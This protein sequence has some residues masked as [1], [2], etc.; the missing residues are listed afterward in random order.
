[1]QQGMAGY[2]W[3]SFFIFSDHQEMIREGFHDDHRNLFFTLFH[4]VN[5]LTVGQASRCA[6]RLANNQLGQI[7]VLNIQKCFHR[8]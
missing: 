1:M 5:E 3:R 6:K 4:E 7:V 8:Q 2:H